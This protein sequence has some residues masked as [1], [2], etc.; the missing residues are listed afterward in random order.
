MAAVLIKGTGTN[1]ILELLEDRVRIRRKRLTALL[2]GGARGDKD[3]LLDQIW[4]VYFEDAT[5]QSKRGYIQFALVGEYQTPLGATLAFGDQNAVM[6][7]YW[8]RKPFISIA[9]AIETY[10]GGS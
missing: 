2:S 1:A 8:D 3:I 4:R 7:H 10:L 6:V 5:W 9:Q